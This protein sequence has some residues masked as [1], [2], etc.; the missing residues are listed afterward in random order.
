MYL[1]CIDS[2]NYRP[3]K[4][5]QRKMMN[6]VGNLTFLFFYFYFLEDGHIDLVSENAIQLKLFLL[7]QYLTENLVV[8][9]SYNSH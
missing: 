8:A 4:D 5:K 9:N 2:V 3:K 1:K 6:L 7:R